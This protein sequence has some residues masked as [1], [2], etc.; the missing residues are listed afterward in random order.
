VFLV[1][2]L[3]AAFTYGAADFLG[4]L[5]SRRANTI[6]VVTISQGAGLLMVAL[7]LPMLTSAAP[8][9]S[10]WIWGGIA[11]LTGGVGVALLYRALA[12]GVMAVVAPTTAVCAV[13]VPVLIAIALG[14]RP[15]TRESLGIGLAVVAIVLV[16][17]SATSGSQTSTS[18]RRL[19]DPGEATRPGLAEGSGLG[20][21]LASGVA[22]GLFFL[23]LARTN[24]AAGLWP[25]LAARAISVSLFAAMTVV[26]RVPL[27]IPPLVLATTVGAGIVDMLANLFFL[28]ASR[29]GPLTLAVT[30]TSLYPASTVLLARVVVGERLAPR[31]WAGVAFAL[32]AIVTIV[33]TTR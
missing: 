8:G 23:S 14:E 12:V 7:L 10:D 18:D 28:L 11:G 26:Y 5:A 4:G 3:T 13:L 24:A 30:L 25:L 29:Q 16:S 15:G 32:V 2:S 19:P 31:Q 9:R 1:L 20:L 6:A 17:Q 21:S 22:I 33:G 27:R